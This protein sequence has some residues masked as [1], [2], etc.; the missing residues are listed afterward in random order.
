MAYGD[1]AF[2][3]RIDEMLMSS[4]DVLRVLSLPIKGEWLDEI[5]AGRKL[6]EYR[7]IKQHY[8]S[9]FFEGVPRDLRD[10]FEM[11]LQCSD[12]TFGEVGDFGCAMKKYDAVELVAGYS[13]TARRSLYEFKGLS[14]KLGNPKWGAPTDRKVFAISLGK[15]LR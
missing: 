6:E 5:D 11:C 13:R 7:D 4:G 1:K 10:L 3:K 8:I 14:V 9:R 2:C 15:K 12:D